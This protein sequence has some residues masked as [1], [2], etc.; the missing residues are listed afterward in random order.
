M[1]DPKYKQG[2]IYWLKNRRGKEDQDLVVSHKRALL[3]SM[4]DDFNNTAYVAVGPSDVGP[5]EWNIVI[6]P[7][8]VR[9]LICFY[10]YT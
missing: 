6:N 9:L 8:D 7:N 5:L 2:L 3:E 1:L 4:V 10:N